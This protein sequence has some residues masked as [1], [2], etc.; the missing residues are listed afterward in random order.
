MII[1]IVEI[2]LGLLLLGATIVIFDVAIYW[3]HYKKALKNE[4]EPL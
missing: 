2:I 3:H 1:L 4:D